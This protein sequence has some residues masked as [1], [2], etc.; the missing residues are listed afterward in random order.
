MTSV[1][2]FFP[3]KRS[4]RARSRKNQPLQFLLSSKP[5]LQ[6]IPEEEDEP[7][8]SCS[9]WTTSSTCNTPDLKRRRPISPHEIRIAKI[10][11]TDDDDDLE[12]FSLLAAPR[13]APRPP[14]SASPASSPDS[15]QLTFTEESFRFPHPPLPT[16]SSSD[17]HFGVQSPISS[18]SSDSSALPLTP[19][20]SDDEFQLPAALIPRRASI[21]PLT[22][23]KNGA[24][25][26]M[27]SHSPSELS[28]EES[29]VSDMESEPES[30]SEWYSREL[31]QIVTL[32]SAFPPNFPKTVRSD[33]A[34]PESMIGSV[35]TGSL[36]PASSAS[37]NFPSPQLDPA[38]PRRRYPIPTRSPPPPPRDSLVPSPVD[39]EDDVFLVRPENPEPRRRPPP[40]MSIP[41]DFG[42]FPEDGDASEEEDD[43]DDNVLTYYIEAEASTPST[44][45][46]SFYSQ[47]SHIERFSISDLEE[48]E[49]QFEVD[50]DL[51][52]PIMLPLSL[53]NT[54]IDLEADIAHGLAELQMRRREAG[55]P[56]DEIPT[57]PTSSLSLSRTPS[58]RRMR[59][60]VTVSVPIAIDWN[61]SE[62]EEIAA[63]EAR[64]EAAAQ[65]Q[66][67]QFLSAPA[68]E[69]KET[70][71]EV[72][73][74]EEPAQDSLYEEYELPLEDDSPVLRSRWS[75]STL[76]S[77]QQEQQGRGWRSS[78]L[79]LY[80]G[81]SK[82]RSN[83]VSSGL[84]SPTTPST[85]SKPKLDLKQKTRNKKRTVVVMGPPSSA[86]GSS[87]WSYGSSP[88]KPPSSP[89]PTS[90]PV[91]GPMSPYFDYSSRSP[92]AKRH[93][94]R[95]SDEVMVIGYGHQPSGA[96][97]RRR[98]STST[99]CSSAAGSGASDA[100]S[101][102]S[103]SSSASSGLRRKPIPVEMFLRA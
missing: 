69:V 24:L 46:G 4:P 21:R 23:V 22:I 40:R 47:P 91:A 20:S 59:R 58:R 8:P 32:R 81:G 61:L 48:G 15:F 50:T 37:S 56:I 25:P 102:R 101:I 64:E 5:D 28:D 96:G 62:E 79:R 99:C 57:R 26:S 38:Y 90:A 88:V 60:N 43:D 84:L 2:S 34:R 94:P 27:F 76:S 6:I 71:E 31:S 51:D 103:G 89:N 65:D 36:S 77:I 98:G 72:V 74:S 35:H 11:I 93:R 12:N 80:F 67:R 14:C 54:P 68:I 63:D 45:S 49:L 39:L 100:S 53:P 55:V 42:F 52:R 41:A 85:P 30:D 87:G 18:P 13:P 33:S 83:S 10:P 70:K 73:V 44:S 19:T 92:A 86:S 9:S 82:K 29:S 95:T 3:L 75:S 7:R 17:L 16:P 66:T 97:V 1:A 78:K